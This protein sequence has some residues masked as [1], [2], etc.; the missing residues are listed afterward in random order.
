VLVKQVKQGA[1][2]CTSTDKTSS[3][4]QLMTL[5]A[6]KMQ[7]ASPTPSELKEKEKRKKRATPS[8]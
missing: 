3:I 1:V 6:L 4:F 8:A 2:G 7:N 5:T